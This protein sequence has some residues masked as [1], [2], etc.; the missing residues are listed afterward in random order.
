M[1]NDTAVAADPELLQQQVFDDTQP[2]SVLRDFRML[3]HFIGADGIPAAGKHNLLPMDCMNDL[4]ERLTRPLR[5]EMKRPQLRSHPYLQALH[6][7]LRATGL[8]QVRDAGSKARL[9]VDPEL[10]A[11]W[12]DLNPTEQ[13]FNLLEAGFIIGRLSMIGERG[14]DWPGEL[15]QQCL[16]AWQRVPA[17]GR[18]FDLSRPSQIYLH[19]LGTNFGLL[20]LLDLFGLMEVEFPDQPVQPWRPAAIRHRPFGDELLGLLCEKTEFG[21]DLVDAEDAGFGHWQPVL[22]PYF[23]AWQK[24]FALPQAESKEGSFVFRVSLGKIVR[25]M[26]MPSTATLDEFMDWILDA[27]EFDNDHLYEFMYRNQRGGLSYARHSYCDEGPFAD[28]IRIGDLPLAPGQALDLLYD[29]GDE[30]RFKIRLERIDP[31]TGEP[32]I[33]KR[34]GKAPRQYRWAEE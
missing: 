17:K 22:Q 29:F 3:L 31:A 25:V 4:D 20:A 32:R 19:G 5:L 13:Y 8:G 7:L 24:R 1:R 14:R 21:M 23:P 16:Q 6:L 30:W 28:D 9:V 33:L 10:L 11:A 26:A 18:K 2:G 34:I 15:F 12:H 27:Y